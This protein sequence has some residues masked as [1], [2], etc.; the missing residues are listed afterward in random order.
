MFLRLGLN[1]EKSLHVFSR[2]RAREKGRRRLGNLVWTR[3]GGVGE[4]RGKE[5]ESEGTW[6]GGE[7]GGER[8]GKRGEV[9]GERQGR[10][11]GVRKSGLGC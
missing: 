8:M 4:A 2:G 6:V 5:W 9:V 3:H 1:K 10:G 7:I 11:E